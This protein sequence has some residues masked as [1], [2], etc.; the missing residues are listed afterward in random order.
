VILAGYPD[1]VVQEASLALD[2]IPGEYKPFLIDVIRKNSPVE[3]LVAFRVGTGNI[4]FTDADR[5]ELAEIAL[6]V[7]L[8]LYPGG[9]ESEAADQLRYQSVVVLQELKWTRATPLVIKQYYRVRKDFVSG[10]APEERLLEAIGCLGAM[11]N[12][13]AAQVLA[14]QL[15]YINSQMER[16]GEYH[17]AETFRTVQA[18]GEIGDKAAFDYLLYIN[19]LPYPEKIQIAAKEALNRLKW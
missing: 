15:G 2:S 16:N 5:G 9:R 6:E 17:E 4:N 19:Y 10:A 8:D 18:L 13:E 11:G 7:S 12:S 3:K 1:A 14:L